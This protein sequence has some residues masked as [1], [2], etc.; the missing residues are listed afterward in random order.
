MMTDKPIKPKFDAA[1]IRDGKPAFSTVVIGRDAWMLLALLSAG[2][3]G[4][5][6]IQRP[7][8]RHS[9]YVFKLRGAGIRVETIDES[10]G[11]SFAGSHARYVLRDEVEVSGGNLDEYL[12]SPEGRREFPGFALHREA[13]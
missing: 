10:H 13:A 3:K 4:V 6:P 5:T 8:P 1:V 12:A 11:G 2:E 9:H 7:A